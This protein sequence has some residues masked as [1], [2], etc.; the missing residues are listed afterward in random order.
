MVS[1]E[2]LLIALALS[3]D[4]F[5]VSMAASASG[6]VNGA[7]SA[8]RLAFHFGLFQFFMPVIGWAA[9]A[10]LE[11]G[12]AAV[13]HWVAFVLLVVVGARMFR[14]GLNPRVLAPH[15]DVSRGMPL[16]ALSTAVSVDALAVGFSLGMLKVDI[17]IPSVVIGLVAMTM[18]L[19][20]IALG[21]GLHARLGRF[22]ELA[23][24]V[25][26]IAIAVKIVLSHLTSS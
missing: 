2:I 5:A 7:V 12:I 26:L 6:R 18:S 13:D 9:G 17:W 24:G 10:T 4:A 3:V 8:G 16:L 22:A 19:I 21:S 11:R 25:V 15:R 23:G 14:A 20:G 1:I